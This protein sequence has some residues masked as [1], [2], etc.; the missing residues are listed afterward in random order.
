[1]NLGQLRSEVYSRSGIP[2]NDGLITASSVTSAINEAMHSVNAEESWEWLQAV[3]TINTVAG[4]DLYTPAANW[5]QSLDLRHTDDRTLNWWNPFELR[6][7]W[8]LIAGGEPIEW[9][10]NVNQILLRPIPDG[11]YPIV[12]T[13]LIMD[14]DLVAD[15]DSP[16][17]P[18]SEHSAIIE[19]ATYLVLRRDSENP[20][21]QLAQQAYTTW[22]AQERGKRLRVVRPYR[23]RVRQGYDL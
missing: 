4:Q 16:L 7:R 11:V 3:E 8:A 12:H 23:V 6:T 13:Y 10:I 22:L 5:R 19:Y 2:L 18:A 20:R 15:G 1:M 17:V 9:A 14:P 21:A